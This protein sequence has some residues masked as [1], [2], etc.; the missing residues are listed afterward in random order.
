[1]PKIHASD[2]PKHAAQQ[3]NQLERKLKNPAAA[4]YATSPPAH[5]SGEVEPVDHADHATEYGPPSPT[6]PHG[7]ARELS[8]L[9]TYVEHSIYLKTQAC[10]SRT[11][12]ALGFEVLEGHAD[13]HIIYFTE[14]L[15]DAP[16]FP[17]DVLKVKDSSVADAYKMFN[18]AAKLPMVFEVTHEGEKGPFSWSQVDSAK[19]MNDGYRTMRQ[20]GRTP[21]GPY[22]ESGGIHNPDLNI[23]VPTVHTAAEAM[24]VLSALDGNTNL[25]IRIS[26]ASMALSG[27]K[28]ATATHVAQDLYSMGDSY[29]S[30]RDELPDQA[31]DLYGDE[32][33][34]TFTNGILPKLLLANSFLVDVEDDALF[35]TYEELHS[36]A[37]AAEEFDEESGGDNSDDGQ[38][39]DDESGEE[40]IEHYDGALDEVTAITA[41]TEAANGVVT[42]MVAK[43]MDDQYPVADEVE[44]GGWRSA[45]TRTVR[46]KSMISKVRTRKAL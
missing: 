45:S 46:K 16:L 33:L 23:F 44:D 21:V 6:S 31:Q 32:K 28:T 37:K 4:A 14:S 9:T 26:K 25:M 22:A 39:S 38:V 10:I 35:R 41:I 40:V 13:H 24:E 2:A 1:M 11:L 12:T 5:S 30:A 7:E 8:M 19:A 3:Q 43:A 18:K 17:G 36:I 20:T 27:D 42:A 15:P 29:S 34:I